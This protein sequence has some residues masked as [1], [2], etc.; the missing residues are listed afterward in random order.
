MAFAILSDKQCESHMH[1]VNAIICNNV[2]NY[3]IFMKFLFQFFISGGIIVSNS[4]IYISNNSCQ[5]LYEW[6]CTFCE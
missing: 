6:F 1:I 2:C 4:Y 5:N 3:I